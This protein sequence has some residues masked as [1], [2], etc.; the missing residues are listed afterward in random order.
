MDDH[1]EVRVMLR[2]G[3]GLRPN[4]EVVGEAGSAATAA[5]LARQ[6]CPDTIVLDLV[7]PD[8]APR[9]TFARMR[10]A[11]PQ[12]QLVVYSA[13]DSRREWYREQ[14]VQFFSKATDSADSLVAWLGAEAGRRRG[15]DGS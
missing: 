10:S 6:L 15:G 13:R 2:V 11:A 5:A 3:L 9:D 4:L 12:S 14:G 8:A 1:R 7:L